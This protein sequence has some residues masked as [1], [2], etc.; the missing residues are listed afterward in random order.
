MAYHKIVLVAAIA[1]SVA[2]TL[3]A[4]L[5]TVTCR[6][7]DWDTG[8]PVESAT[9]VAAF[10]KKSIPFRWENSIPD[11]DVCERQTDKGGLCKLR[12][13]TDKGRVS[14]AIKEPPEGFYSL[15]YGEGM[16]FSGKSLLGVWQ[17][18]NLVVTLRLQR[19]V[20]PV[21]LFVKEIS[22]RG[23]DE[24]GFGWVDGTNHV[25]KFDVLKGDWL[26][27]HGK[28][29]FADFILKSTLTIT[30]TAPRPHSPDIGEMV[31]F[32]R[33]DTKIVFVGEYNGIKLAKTDPMMGIK[34]R[35]ADSDG[36]ERTSVAHTLEFKKVPEKIPSRFVEDDWHGDYYNSYRPDCDVPNRHYSFRVR[37]KVN[38][39][40]ELI[41][42]YYGKIYGGFA[43][44]ADDKRGLR[45]VKFL[46][47]LNPQS[48]DRNLEWDMK[49]VI[50]PDLSVRKFRRGWEFNPQP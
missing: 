12:G 17:P 50:N 24:H 1:L 20:R 37:S 16:T 30:G 36:F 29:E 28:G 27:P 11:P 42:A 39:K 19:V 9:V 45:R 47:Y 22:L 44:N 8:E 38:D 15:R 40:G 43:V 3:F 31:D 35:T 6:V 41:K 46:Y 7:E 21:P 14:I 5:A 10:E 18:D 34:I 2:G 33:I 23:D 13:R 49:N 48:L 26:P 32:Y 25:L 4:D